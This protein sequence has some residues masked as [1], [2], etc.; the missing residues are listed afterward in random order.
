LPVLIEID[1]IKTV[2]GAEVFPEDVSYVSGAARVGFDEC[3]FV[4]TDY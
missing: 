3:D 1:A 4:A 2:F